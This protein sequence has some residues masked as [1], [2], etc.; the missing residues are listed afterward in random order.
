MDKETILKAAQAN[1]DAG[2]EFETKAGVKS[3]LF[4]EL[5]ALI[6]GIILFLTEYFVKMTWNVGLV[7]V[8]FSASGSQMLYEGIAIKSVWR[9]VLGAAQIIIALFFRIAFIGQVIK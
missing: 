4:G 5:V 6:I 1:K 2:R 3:S 7:A 9:I 8:A